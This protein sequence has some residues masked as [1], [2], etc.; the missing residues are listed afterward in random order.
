MTEYDAMTLIATAL[1]LVMLALRCLL[2]AGEKHGERSRDR[3][4]APRLVPVR[5]LV[6]QAR[7]RLR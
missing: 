5:L 3:A 1:G 6:T 4:A 2:N 7:G